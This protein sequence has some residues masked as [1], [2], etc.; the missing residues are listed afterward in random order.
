MITLK[1]YK[2]DKA[3]FLS[4]IDVLRHMNRT[5]RRAGIDVQFSQGFNPHMLTKLGIPLPLA[6]FSTCE[7]VTVQ[8]NEDPDQ[9]LAKYNS[10]CIKG[11][12]GI[13][14]FYIPKNPNLA[15]KV[16]YADYRIKA[17][18]LDKAKEIENLIHNDTFVVDYPTRK[19]PDKK[20]DI[21]PDIKGIRCGDDYIDVCINA[22]NM[23]ADV[24]AVSL[25]RA[26]GIETFP[27][28]VTRI[29]QYVQEGSKLVDVDTYLESLNK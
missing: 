14:A 19:E 10:A 7:Y 21:I 16:A 2:R 6:T 9:F 13:K 3:V 29:A 4:H 22:V 18:P 26:F 27:D 15:G 5:F 25:S 23:R 8:T 17:K 28:E 11:M 12:E 24:L 1:Y 20:R